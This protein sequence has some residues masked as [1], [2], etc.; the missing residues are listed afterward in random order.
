MQKLT[1]P[2]MLVMPNAANQDLWRMNEGDF[3]EEIK[4][5]VGVADGSKNVTDDGNGLKRKTSWQHGL[6]QNDSLKL[7]ATLRSRGDNSG[8]S[9]I[10]DGSETR[11]E[12]FFC[13]ICVL[14]RKTEVNLKF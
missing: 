12:E 13:S 2:I 1:N 14:G 6:H 5:F 9:A 3:G 10:Y 4:K 11:L 7:L 8:F